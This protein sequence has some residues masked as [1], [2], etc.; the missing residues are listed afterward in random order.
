MI[1]QWLNA[2]KSGSRF[3]MYSLFS[4]DYIQSIY[5]IHIDTFC[6]VGGI[7]QVQK[8]H[9]KHLYNWREEK[10]TIHCS[11]ASQGISTSRR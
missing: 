1:I 11:V 3:F 2:I 7:E 8:I 10:T 5:H 4:L 6:L 9:N